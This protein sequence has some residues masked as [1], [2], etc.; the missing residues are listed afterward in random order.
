MSVFSNIK[1]KIT[2]RLI[3]QPGF[4]TKSQRLSIQDQ[5]QSFIA[6]GEGLEQVQEKTNMDSF[7]TSNGESQGDV[8]VWD[9]AN[10][11]FDKAPRSEFNT[12]GGGT[13]ATGA[14]AVDETDGL[15]NA[16]SGDGALGV[17]QTNG[18]Q[19]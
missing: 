11:R 19:R 14:L 17:D 18:L 2:L 10:K 8:I 7:F 5:D 9:N 12:G 13:P 3:Q 16:G 6:L 15:S 4:F 1:D